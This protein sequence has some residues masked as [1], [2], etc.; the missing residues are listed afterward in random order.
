MLNLYVLSMCSTKGTLP[1]QAT[2][3]GKT[4]NAALLD[5]LIGYNSVSNA[6]QIRTITKY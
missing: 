1:D 2:A 3:L 5:M 6:L 4:D